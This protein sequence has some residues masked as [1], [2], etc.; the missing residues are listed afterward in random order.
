MNLLWSRVVK[1]NL[2]LDIEVRPPVTDLCGAPQALYGQHGESKLVLDGYFLLVLLHESGVRGGWKI[3]ERSV[4]DS[5]PSVA[6]CRDIVRCEGDLFG[7]CVTEDGK[8][9][10][11]RW[12]KVVSRYVGED[13][14]LPT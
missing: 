3:M 5:A 14:F 11:P 1:V 12:S 9:N 7:F 8:S 2:I 13:E 6:L 10:S 4:G